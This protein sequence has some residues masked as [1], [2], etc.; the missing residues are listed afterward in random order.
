MAS[1]S[2]RESENRRPRGGGGGDS[3][4]L[5]VYRAVVG[6]MWW[7]ASGMRFTSLWSWYSA[8]TLA[9]FGA[10]SSRGTAAGE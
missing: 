1:V 9:R 10:A 6:S 3:P 8:G 4:G 7:Q 2:G 5:E